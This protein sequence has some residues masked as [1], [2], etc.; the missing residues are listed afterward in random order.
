MTMRMPCARHS[1]E[2]SQRAFGP[3]E[4]DQHVATRERTPE[5]SRDANAARCTHQFTGILA[6]R[7]IAGKFERR[8]EA[9]SADCAMA[10][11]NARPMRPELPATAIC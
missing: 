7:G 2:M 8:L 10:S 6:E 3:G 5:I 9:K 4:I 1:F 11:I